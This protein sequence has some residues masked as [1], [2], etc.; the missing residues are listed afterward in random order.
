MAPGYK[1]AAPEASPTTTLVRELQH[2]G[3][4]DPSVEHRSDLDNEQEDVVVNRA[5]ANT[6]AKPPPAAPA[7]TD[8]DAPTAHLDQLSL[9]D[10]G[11]GKAKGKGKEPAPA[12][13][14]KKE[15]RKSLKN[16]L[17]STEHT[18]RL[19]ADDGSEHK[20]VLTSWKMAD[21]AYKREPCPFPTRARGLFTE[22]VRG[23]KP[24]EE[25]EYRI[26]ARGYDKFF[27]IGEVSWTHVR[28]PVSLLQMAPPSWADSVRH[29]LSQWNTIAQHSTGP[30]ELTTK[31]NGC[32]ILIAALDAKHLVVTSKH[33]IGNN[34][35]ANTE[36]GVSHS[37]RGEYW[38][39]QH[40]ERVG[41]TKEDLA[42]ELFERNLTAVAEVRQSLSLGPTTRPPQTDATLV[43]PQLCDDEFE[44]HVL[45]YPADQTGLHL[46][47]LNVNE[48]ILNTLPSAE[49][50]A[51]ARSW[52]MISTSYSVFPSVPAVQTY[53]E[54]VQADGGV[55]G[56][57]GKVTPVEGFVVRGHRRGGA[58]GEAFFWK[59][60]YD[61]PYLM[62]REWREL[63]RKLL[64]AYPNV[65]TVSPAKVR[66]EDSRLYL[67]WVAR[68]IKRDVD[69]FES[70]K[71]G[72]G[73]IKTREEFLQWAKTPEANVARREL[74]VKVAVSEEERKNRKFDKTIIVPVAIQG[75]GASPHYLPLS[76]ESER[77]AD[78]PLHPQA[79]PPS[80]SSC[81]TSLAGVTFRATTSCRRS[82]H[83]TSCER[84]RNS[85]KSATWSLPTSASPLHRLRAENAC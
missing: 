75:C 34:A 1:K 48:P 28:L 38:L 19:V 67:R 37:Q 84:S 59:V 20:R 14:G 25:E 3:Q 44:E 43:H 63:T 72:K 5:S 30:Y 2:F 42:K 36:G 56:P 17:R 68:E 22:R 70:W 77:H 27:N 81:R 78:S 69:R 61:E 29:L 74:G 62:Y 57:D 10:Q 58:P 40:V 79:R 85:S 15:S 39:E 49:V 4:D 73:I 35:N 24:G 53:C 31:S 46:H 60:K 41:R 18:I 33:S 82:P 66:N 6:V 32:I 64:A 11:K 55:E 51:F 16:L 71:H 76:Y 52:G 7:S 26:V 45:P 12:A 65:E 83:R 80:A 9:A 54:R 13:K 50:S 21:Y 8:S 47:G 23:D